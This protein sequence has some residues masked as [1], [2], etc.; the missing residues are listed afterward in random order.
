MKSLL[1]TLIALLLLQLCFAQKNTSPA[2]FNLL[3]I[4]DGMP[5]GTV[6]DLLQDKAGYIWVATLKGLV[7]YDGYTTRVYDFGI[8]DP[9]ARGVSKIFEDSKGQLWAGVMSALYKYDRAN[10]RFIPY[11]FLKTGVIFSFTED[12]RGN[13]WL[14]IDDYQGSLMLLDPVTKK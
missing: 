8:E 2:H 11:L 14:L 4:K 3:S 1:T 9:N 13:L 12:K 10:D 5:E 6:N 7:R